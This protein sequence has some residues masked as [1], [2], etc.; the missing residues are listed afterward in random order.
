MTVKIRI[1]VTFEKEYWGSEDKIDGIYQRHLAHSDFS[2]QVYN[3]SK[4]EGGSGHAKRNLIIGD[5]VLTKK[6]RRDK[7]SSHLSGSLKE[8]RPVQ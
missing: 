7:I 1:Q 5:T 4:C 3:Q 8:I 2:G 6:P